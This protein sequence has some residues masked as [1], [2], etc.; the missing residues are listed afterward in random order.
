MTK[1]DRGKTRTIK[2]RA[3]YVY[4]P[5]LEMVEDWKERARRAGVSISKFVME[6]VED[7]IRREGEEGYLSRLELIKHLKNAEEE[8]KRLRNEN[9]LLKRLVDNLDNE[10]RRYRASSFTEEG[11]E[12]ARRFDRELVELLRK[13]G[14]YRD[15]EILVHLNI[16]PSDA[17]LVRAV[18]KQLEILEAYGL[19]EYVGRGW[20]WKE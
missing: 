7:S 18:A 4:L 2:Q 11:F 5:S 14:S 3:I 20:R 19:V 15:E 13:G 1:P 12:G 17:E 10:L 6:R 8:L 9:R 16:D